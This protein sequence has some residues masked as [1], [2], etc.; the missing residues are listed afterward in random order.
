MAF[1]THDARVERIL[2][3]RK[4][5][6]RKTL[7]NR[8][9][10]KCGVTQKDTAIFIEYVQDRKYKQV[11]NSL[12]LMRILGR[13]KEKN[14]ERERESVCYLLDTYLQESVTKIK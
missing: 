3:G 7:C 12:S 4:Y 14:A 10:L 13:M 11:N 1:R 9:L 8:W 6:S 5:S 2:Q